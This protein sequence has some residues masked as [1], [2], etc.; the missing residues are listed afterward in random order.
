MD[1]YKSNSNKSR[2]E[3]KRVAN[4]VVTGDVKV[5]DKSEMQ[6]IADTFIAEDVKNVKN[7]ILSDVLVPVIKKAVSDIVTNGVNMILYGEPKKGSTKYDGNDIQTS[8]RSYYDEKNRDPR[9]AQTY[10]RLYSFKNVIL[11]TRI[12]AENVLDQMNAILNK[13]GSVTVADYYDLVGAP[14]VYTD[15]KYGWRDLR[16]AYIYRNNDDSYSLKLPKA[17][18]LD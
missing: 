4:K 10:G 2:S 18:P 13:Y 17:L 5:K 1:E 14:N 8:Y 11:A 6:K 12:D 16:S 9:N 15:Y 3:D 7:Y